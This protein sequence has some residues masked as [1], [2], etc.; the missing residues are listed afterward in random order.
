MKIHPKSAMEKGFTS[1]L[2]KSVTPDALDVV[3]HLTE[4]P[5]IH[6]HE[7]RNDH[8]PDQDADRQV[9]LGN[10]EATD[11]LKNTGQEL[12]ERDADDD[13]QEDPNGQVAFEDTHSALSGVSPIAAI[14]SLSRS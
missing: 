7:H 4:R 8:H 11:C 6:F 5:E 1:Q 2:T 9:H 10:R 14:C 13:A 3:A 12:A